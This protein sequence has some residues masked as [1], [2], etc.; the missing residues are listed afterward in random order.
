MEF[1]ERTKYALATAVKELMKTTPLD[2]ITVSEIVAHC[3]T[4]RQTLYRNFK[5]KYDL[6]NWYFDKI[7][8]KTIRQMGLSLTIEEGLI[9]KLKL[10]KEDCYF[11]ISAFS[12]SDYNSLLRYDY[13]CIYHFF[14]EIIRKRGT[15]TEDIDMLLQYYCRSAL[16][17]TGDW[18]LHGMRQSP[19]YMASLLIDLMPQKIYLC[20]YPLADTES[21]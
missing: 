2:K 6:V 19:E 16:D 11:F 7:V 13:E 21:F 8:Q 17:M 9:K 1:Q 12:S 14:R 20:L 15:V 10:M 4:T 18:V 5:D 3:G